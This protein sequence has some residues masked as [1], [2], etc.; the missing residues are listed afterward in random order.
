MTRCVQCE[1][2]CLSWSRK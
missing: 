1:G 2:L